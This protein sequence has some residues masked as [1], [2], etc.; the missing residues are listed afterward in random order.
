MR[1]CNTTMSDHKQIH[2]A[3]ATDGS[4]RAELALKILVCEFLGSN[5]LVT[6]MSLTDSTKTHLLDRYTPDN[7]T[8]TTNNFLLSHVES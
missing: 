1:F 6:V 4:E 3:M 5:D 7:I 8:K 2:F